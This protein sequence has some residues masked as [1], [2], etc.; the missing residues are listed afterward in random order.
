LERG[1][2]LDSFVCRHCTVRINH[3]GL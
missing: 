1:L 2:D 3:S